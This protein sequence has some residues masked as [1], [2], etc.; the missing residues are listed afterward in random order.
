MSPLQDTQQT[1][2][3]T[4]RRVTAPGRPLVDRGRQWGARKVGILASLALLAVVSVVHV[5][6][7]EESSSRSPDPAPASLGGDWELAW[8]DEFDGTALDDDKWSTKEPWTGAPGFVNDSEAWLPHPATS[9]NLVVGAGSVRIDARRE[10]LARDNGQVMT[11]AMLTSRGKYD[12]FTHGV[13]EARVRLPTGQGLWPAFWLLGNGTGSE[14]WPATG[15]IDVFEFVNNATGGA[16]RMYS[17]VHWGD[18][19]EGSVEAH[20]AASESV[21]VPW[22]GDDEFHTFTLHRTPDFLRFYVDGAQVMEL[23]PGED[24]PSYPRTVPV[25]GPLFEDPMHVRLSL[26]V[27][28]PWA[29]DGHSAAQ[30]E[31]GSLVVD[32]VRAWE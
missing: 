5:S 15:E 11:T 9:A 31:P 8:S 24:V 20:H 7:D 1:A 4:S 19:V 22:W 29:G 21:A 26:E 14:G 25:D 3:P 16:G 2:G 13:I 32:Y 17:S 10:E 18:V 23:L 12:S 30:Y 28:G 6:D 27:G